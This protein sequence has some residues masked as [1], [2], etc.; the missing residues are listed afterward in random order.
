MR[1]IILAAGK[2]SRFN[3]PNAPKPLTELINGL[4]ILEYQLI[5]IEKFLSLENVHIVVGFQKEKIISKFPNLKYIDNPDYANENTAK[6]LLK[7]IGQQHEDMLWLNGDVVFHPAVLEKA[8]LSKGSG[9]I[10][11]VGAVGEEEI[12]YRTNLEG[13]IAE[14]SK[15]VAEPEGEA[16]G[17]NIFKAE[18]IPSLKK[19]LE[20]CAAQDYFEKAIEFCIQEGMAIQPI[21][22]DR[23]LCTE[24]D[25]PED[26]DYANRLIQGW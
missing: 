2:G 4:S 12:K 26:L 13:N 19:N 6:S 23:P 10:V 20:R 17:I 18:D 24:I 11:N 9:M 7:A 22:V 16:L 25:F 1:V 5:Q 8:I 15:K 3:D 14:V 21:Q